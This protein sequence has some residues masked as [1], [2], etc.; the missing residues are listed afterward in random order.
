MKS[1]SYLKYLLSDNISLRKYFREKKSVS[2]KDVRRSLL[3]KVRTLG[4]SVPDHYYRLG[5][6][7]SFLDAKELSELFTVGLPKLADEYLEIH[8]GRV[9][10]KGERMNDW[11]LLLPI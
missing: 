1:E 3:I 11:Q 10:V 4:Y 6:E 9:Y 7:A 5:T 2:L 8:N